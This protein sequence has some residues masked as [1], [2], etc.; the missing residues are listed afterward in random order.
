MSV[1]YK[2]ECPACGG[3]NLYV[4]PQ[5]GLSY[6]YNCQYWHRE[7]EYEARDIKRSDHIDDIRA[8]Y[9]RMAHYYHECLTKEAL[10]FLY[11]RG[12]DDAT[13]QALK[14]GY[15]PEEKSVLYKQSI[16]R[17]AGLSTYDGKSALCKRVVFPY[18]VED[19]TVTDIRG[20]S[21]DPL[22]E[23][24][25]KSP[26]GSAHYRGADYPYNWQ[27]QCNKPD[28]IIITEGEIKAAIGY[29]FK[30]PIIA[31]P[32]MTTWRSGLKLD[33]KQKPIIIFD[34]QK[35]NRRDVIKA[36]QKVAAHLHE[37]LVGTLPLMGNTKMD[38][39]TLIITCGVS[40]FDMVIDTAIQYEEWLDFQ[41]RF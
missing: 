22:D 25:Y 16:A 35:N 31:L 12:F 40:M 21:L 23:L 29:K 37:P 36:V 9:T 30:Y 19:G 15:V 26:Y 32:G 1:G 24:R 39:D 11:G 5:N 28:K 20:R 4:T 38:I 8:Y 17:E 13:I 27:L 14:I 6:C 33:R 2:I 3:G 34:N 18:M 7:G 41:Q 10:T